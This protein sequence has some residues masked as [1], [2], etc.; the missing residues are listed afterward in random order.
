MYTQELIGSS[1]VEMYSRQLVGY[2]DAEAPH[3]ES[4]GPSGHAAKTFSTL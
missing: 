1:F 2:S 3:Q 4:S